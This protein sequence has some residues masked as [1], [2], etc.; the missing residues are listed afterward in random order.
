MDKF[1]VT[2][3]IAY[4]NAKP[5]IGFALE[6]LQADAL[7]RWHALLEQP[8]YFLTGTDEH[9]RKVAKAAEEAG[10]DPK[11]FVDETSGH[12]SKLAEALNISNDD[13]VRTSDQK[14]H[15]PGVTALWKKLDAADKLYKASYEGLYCSGCE[16]FKKPSDLV[17]GR[18]PN[19]NREPEKVR[20]ENW[21][22]RLSEYGPA[23]K[24]KI[25]SGEFQIVPESRQNEVLSFIDQG[26]E[27][28]SFSRPSRDLS[29]G[30]PVPGDDS[31]T[32]YVWA[33]ALS[34]YMTAV[35]YGRDEEMFHTWW[36]ADVHVIGKDITR[37]HAIIWPAMLMAAELPLPKKLLVHGFIQSGGQKMSKSLGNVVDPFDLI[38]R[39]G[40]DPVRYYLLHEVPTTKDGDFTEERFREV[41]AGDLQKTIG[42]LLARVT[43]I[44]EGKAI[45]PRVS[46]AARKVMDIAWT[47]YNRAFKQFELH[48]A[49]E[50]AV[51]L[52]REANEFIEQTKPWE[53]D[54]AAADALPQLA[55]ML[56]SV[57]WMLVPFLPDTAKKM[58]EQLGMDP[59]HDS[60]WEGV[61]I[62]MQKGDPLFPRLQ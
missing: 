51:N 37:F 20:E 42:N 5:H 30:V 36:P 19:H 4:A 33:D 45:E 54:D 27:D 23:L 43:K 60:D 1:Y 59:K 18:C 22:F 31:Q 9:G 7:A 35:G 62:H 38:E 6:L 21:F 28:V 40:V 46:V 58:F 17:D 34:N 26:L 39:Y 61:Q 55:L 12:F 44:G 48:N 24:K 41:Y 47:D 29:W 3:A 8:R 53:S 57:A 10:Q 52:A 25:Q 14:K 11:T 32:M 16:E 13:F 49:L 56:H 15:W 2:T 50:A